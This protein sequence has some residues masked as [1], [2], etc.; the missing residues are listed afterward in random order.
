M[1]MGRCGVVEGMAEARAY[2]GYYQATSSV[3]LT[4]SFSP[5]LSLRRSVHHSRH[6]KD[7]VRFKM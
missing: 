1:E 3:C 7:I 6:S 4:S 5:C 2:D